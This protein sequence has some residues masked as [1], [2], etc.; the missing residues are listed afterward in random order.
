MQQAAKRHCKQ[1]PSAWAFVFKNIMHF[2]GTLLVGDFTDNTD[3][4]N[5]RD[6]VMPLCTTVTYTHPYVINR[7]TVF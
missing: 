1:M 5:S 4:V 7:Y 6:S 3:G 2:N